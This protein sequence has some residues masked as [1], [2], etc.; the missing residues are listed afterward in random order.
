MSVISLVDNDALGKLIVRLT[1]GIL[2]LFHGVAKILNPGAVG[3]I[4]SKLAEAG[5]PSV[6]AYGVYVGEVI[7]P[8]MIIL[9]IFCRFGAVLTAGNMVVA[10]GLMH[11]GEIFALTQ[12]GGWALELQGF[13]LFI[14]LAIIFLG[15][16]KY[17]V[18]P[19]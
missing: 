9:G 18:R 11:M 12:T 4:G 13:F 2:M 19:D 3:F 5:L 17:A 7:A 10:I 1:L 6:I 8:V 14:S 16:G 15:S